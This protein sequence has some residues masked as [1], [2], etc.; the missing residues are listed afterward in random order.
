[1]AFD[2]LI[3]LYMTSDIAMITPVR[4]GMNLVAKEFIATRIKGDGV[5][6]LSEMAG[7]SKELYESLLINPFDLNQMA[8]ALLTAIQ[9]P[10]EEQK[11]RNLSMQKRLRRYSVELWANEFMKALKTKHHSNEESSVIKISEDIQKTFVKKFKSAKKRMIFLDYDGTLVDY[12]QKP[13]RA[14]P[15]EKLLQLIQDLIVFPPYRIG[16][17]KW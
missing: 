15:D 7:A 9:M 16:H 11:K 14:V 13:D 2:D 1:M 12:H 6:I 5:L 8:E 3:D 17:C 10:V 4:D